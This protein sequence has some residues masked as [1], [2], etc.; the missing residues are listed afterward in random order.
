GKPGTEREFGDPVDAGI[1]WVTEGANYLHLVDLD[2]AMGEGDNL[3]KVAEVLASVG[4]GVEVGGG[5]RSVDRGCEL[6]GIGADRVILGTAA[7]KDPDIVYELAKIAGPD[8]VV[9]ALD[10]RGGKVAYEGWK[11][12]S[13]R[14][15]IEV[16]K[17]FENLGIG[18]ILFTNVDV[19]G[20]MKGIEPE[21]IR[22]LVE[23][24]DLPAI[25]A[26]GVRSRRD[27]VKAK[28]TG[29]DALVIGRA[30]YEGKITLKEAMEAAE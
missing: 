17:E 8:R 18:G 6:L 4:V 10:A 13:E 14:G 25:A 27:V 16:A 5:I 28:E 11:K 30:L 1:K 19:E 24:I 23:A 15:V 7:L 3:K 22:E 29:A 20:H 12:T 9:V 26:G 2:A 21:S